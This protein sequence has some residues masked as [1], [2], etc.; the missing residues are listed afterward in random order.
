MSNLQSSSF[1]AHF[2]N[3]NDQVKTMVVVVN[4]AIGRDICTDAD[5]VIV[6]SSYS[7][8]ITDGSVV[9]NTREINTFP[10]L[11]GTYWVSL[12]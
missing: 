11:L 2:Q 5:D 9:I 3:L 4:S 1:Q 6:V 8:M 7:F 12:K 10:S